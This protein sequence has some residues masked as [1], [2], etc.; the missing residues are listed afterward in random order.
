MLRLYDG[1]Y[2]EDDLDLI[3]ED[4]P[5]DADLLEAFLDQIDESQEAL[6]ALTRRRSEHP[7]PLFN[8]RAIECFH[9]NGYN[10]YRIRPLR[11]LHQYRIIYAFDAPNDAFYVLAISRK[12]LHDAPR[13][14]D[15][16]RYNYEPDHPLSHRIRDEY[17]ELG[18]PRLPAR[19]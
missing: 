12:K 11:L 10:V 18:I 8:E 6:W 19:R 15:P 17:D 14:I 3:A 2:L 13:A 7:D 9:D 4:S 1:A 16:K 5:E